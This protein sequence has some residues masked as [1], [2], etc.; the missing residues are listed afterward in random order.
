MS[1]AADQGARDPLRDLCVIIPTWNSGNRLERSLRSVEDEL[2]PARIIVV[3][4]DS[5]DGTPEIARRH[6]ATVIPDTVS[7]GSARIK[8]VGA[9]G[10]EWVCFVDDDVVIPPGFRE[11]TQRL[12]DDRTGAVQGAVISVH[13]P[14]R[15]MLVDSYEGRFRGGEAY[16]L[17]PGDRGLTSA[18]LVRRSLIEDLDLED[19][20]TWEDW[21]MTQKVLDSGHR[22]IV[23]RLYV[24]HFHE[25]EDLPRKEG[26]NAAGILNLGRTGRMPA[27]R[28]LWWYAHAALRGPRNAFWVTARSRD[29]RHFLHFSRQTLSV[30]LAPFYMLGEASR[31]RA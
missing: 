11:R 2:R 31:S 18:T 21:L 20:D 19:I 30:L 6:G 28:A 14:Y 4:R 26:R 16:D 15:D 27:R 5:R 23:A 22:W 24:D 25:L 13:Q 17:G 12:L 29:P 8:G 9:S 10:S 3:D 7:L 1:R